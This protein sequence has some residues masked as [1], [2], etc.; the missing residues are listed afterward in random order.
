MGFGKKLLLKAEEMT[1]NLGLRSVAVIAGVGVRNYYRKQGYLDRDGAGQFQIKTLTDEHCI[2]TH[3]GQKRPVIPCITIPQPPPCKIKLQEIVQ[4]GAYEEMLAREKAERKSKHVRA[5]YDPNAPEQQHKKKA[6]NFEEADPISDMFGLD[7]DFESLPTAEVE[8][9][10]EAASE[11]NETGHVNTNEHVTATKNENAPI[12]NTNADAEKPPESID[13]LRDEP[14]KPTTTTTTKKN[15]AGKKKTEAKTEQSAPLVQ[16]KSE[17]TSS[18]TST[19]VPHAL[20]PNFVETVIV[21]AL[22]AFLL[23]V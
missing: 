1:Y 22:V 8:E 19:V 17:S 5:V 11:K 12:T 21:V 14:S 2:V 4:P 9:N 20:I 13:K 6:K 16:Q 10:L 23:F 3:E 15:G 7:V 18:A